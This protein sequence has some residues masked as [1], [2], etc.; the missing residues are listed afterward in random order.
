MDVGGGGVDRALH[1]VLVSAL[2]FFFADGA[3]AQTLPN[4]PKLIVTINE[5]D[6][7][8]GGRFEFAK[9][10][11]LV[12]IRGIRQIVPLGFY[13]LDPANPWPAGDVEGQ[14]DWLSRHATRLVDAT[15]G[16]PVLSNILS[17]GEQSGEVGYDGVWSGDLTV[18]IKEIAGP[19]ESAPF[20]IR[21][22]TPTVVYGDNVA[23][24]NAQKGWNARL[25]PAE[26]VSFAG[27]RQQFSGGISDVAPLVV[28]ITPGSYGPGQDWYL[29]TRRYTYV[30]GDPNSRPTL[31]LDELS[32]ARKSMF[33]VANLNLRNVGIAHT[34][35]LAG[36]PNTMIIRNTYQCCEDRDNNGIVNPN[37]GTGADQWS[38]YWH[39]SESKG[40]G[41]VGNS[42]H[43]IYAEGRPKSLIDVNNLR[44]LGSRG[45]SGIKTTMAEINVRHSLVQVAESLGEIE[46]GICLHPGYSSGCLMH[47]PIDF[48]G[49]TA[50]TIYANKFVVWRGPTQG[51][52]SG[53]SGVL[54]ATIFIRQR[55]P[56]YGSDIP[57]YP[58]KSWDPPASTQSTKVSPCYQW[59]GTAKTYVDNRFWQDV[60][61]VALVDPA[62]PCTFK[63]FISYNLFVQVPG[64]LRVFA[65]RDDGTYA[66]KA[67]SQFSTTVNIYRT[68]PSWVERSTSFLHG[69]LYEGY[70]EQTLYE[71]D[72]NPNIK[73]IDPLSYWPRDPPDQFPRL[74]DDLGEELPPWFKL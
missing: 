15:S 10:P 36:Y 70:G 41:G 62:N 18:R 37:T 38:I 32:G 13:Q 21:V 14:S 27:C 6:V 45:S 34:G 22:L 28:F 69:N 59:D 30:I 53:R 25:C 23:S 50:A 49:F 54:S 73:N 24:I 56:S 72:R 20:R 17:Y 35:A 9:I 29:S 51:V 57:N 71:L 26:T 68:S 48:P 65:V 12:L 58:N 2:W 61:K 44:L 3:L 64:S 60:A 19:A 66:A 42:T 7:A 74:I 47:T 16:A 46:N 8:A 67:T 31:T 1:G 33:Y 55:G 4:P 11:E 43:P 52:P 39:Q 63:H 5:P 40:M